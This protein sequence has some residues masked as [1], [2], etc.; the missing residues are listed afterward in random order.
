MTGALAGVML[1]YT[2]LMKFMPY[3]SM[4][5]FNVEHLVMSNFLTIKKVVS[6][7]ENEVAGFVVISQLLRYFNVEHLVMSN[8]LTIKILD[9]RKKMK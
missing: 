6:Y 3:K 2:T 5:I 8:F 1:F 4:S 9:H 7:K